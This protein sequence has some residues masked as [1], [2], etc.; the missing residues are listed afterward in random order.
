MT[1][2]T[3]RRPRALAGFEVQVRVVHALMMREMQTRFGHSK[4]GF[5]WLMLE[6]MMLGGIIGGVH[7]L[8][9]GGVHL[10]PVSP[11]LLFLIGYL[12]Y[13][14]FRAIVNR[15]PSALPANMTLM[16]HRQVRLFDIVIARNILESAAVIAVIAL[17]VIGVAWVMG[18]PPYSV[19]ALVF[20]LVMLCLYSHGLAMLAAAGCAMSDTLE[21][22]IH[23][24]TYIALPFS[25]G[26]FTL[27]SLPP[28]LRDILL[29]NPQ[30]HFHE[31][32]RHGM[33]GP[34]MPWYFDVWYMIATTAIVNLLG[35][36]ALRAVRPKLAF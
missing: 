5:M 23:P 24:L 3:V 8:K 25:G 15:A 18:T 26:M 2:A 22:L 10:Y 35:M 17:L 27:H 36:L 32:V 11:F 30:P 21:R 33:F 14:A 13:F 9:D 28:T 19:P 7:Y 4:L 6:P 1:T 34:V 20:G 12:P 31:I 29:W 16:Y